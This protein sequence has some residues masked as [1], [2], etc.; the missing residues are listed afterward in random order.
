MHRQR[1]PLG[2]RAK[3]K[4]ERKRHKSRYRH[5][6]EYVVIGHDERLLLNCASERLKARVHISQSMRHPRDILLHAWIVCPQGFL[7]PL[8]VE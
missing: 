1:H 6:Q 8:A 4:H 2:E 3:E 5:R 7:H